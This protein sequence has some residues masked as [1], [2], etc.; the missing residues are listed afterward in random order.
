[1]ARLSL[2]SGAKVVAVTPFEVSLLHGV[3]HC[4]VVP[5]VFLHVGEGHQLCQGGDAV[6][7][8]L[9][10]SQGFLYLFQVGGGVNGF[11]SHLDGGGQ[12]LLLGGA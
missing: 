4:L 5:G 1:M 2:L 7:G 3:Q 6:N 11:L 12:R 8:G 9:G 10:G